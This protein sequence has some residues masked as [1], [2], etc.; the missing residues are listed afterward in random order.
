LALL[1]F[2]ILHSLSLCKYGPSSEHQ[3][4]LLFWMIVRVGCRGRSFQRPTRCRT[5]SSPAYI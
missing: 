1:L 5:A 3:A 2:K 4:Q